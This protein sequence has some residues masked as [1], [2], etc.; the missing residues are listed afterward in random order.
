ME[1]TERSRDAQAGCDGSALEAPGNL[2][3]RPFLDQ[4]QNEQFAL[5]VREVCDGSKDSRGK[6]QAFVD[7]LEVGVHD[8]DREA[9]TLPS[10]V[11]DPSLAQGGPK[12][13]V[14]DAIEPRQ[15]GAIVLVSEPLSAM[16]RRRKDLGG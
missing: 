15:C 14:S 11:L 7:G 1:T 6:R 16:P 9:Q 12:H 3:I 13:I 2:P 4:A 8:G 5:G 10:A